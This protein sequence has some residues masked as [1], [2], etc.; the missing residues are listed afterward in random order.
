MSHVFVKY[1]DFCLY[2]PLPIHWHSVIF[3]GVK[4]NNVFPIKNYDHEMSTDVAADILALTAIYQ[5]MQKGEEAIMEM[6][7]MD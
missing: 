5:M 2:L 7:D 1:H 4:A 6:E 3:Q